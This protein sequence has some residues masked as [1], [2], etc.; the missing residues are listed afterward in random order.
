MELTL[1]S[2]FVMLYWVRIHGSLGLGVR[3]RVLELL[4]RTMLRTYAQCLH[5]IIISTEKLY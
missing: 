5:Y 2:L 3:V 4:A 1:N